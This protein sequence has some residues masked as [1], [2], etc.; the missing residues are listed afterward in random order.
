MKTT[1][2]KKNLSSNGLNS[3]LY[4]HFNDPMVKLMMEQNQLLENARLQMLALLNM[5]NLTDNY[6]KKG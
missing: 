3:S 5:Q 2:N 4:N 6:N 1:Q